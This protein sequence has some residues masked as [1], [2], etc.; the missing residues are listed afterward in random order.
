MIHP[1]TVPSNWIPPRTY[2]RARKTA[3]AAAELAA[4]T[5]RMSIYTDES[6]INNKVG[7]AAWSIV[8]GARC[9]YLGHLDEYTVYF[10][11]VMA[12]DLDLT[13]ILEH[14]RS[15]KKVPATVHIFI[16]NQA[17]ILT[18]RNPKPSSG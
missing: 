4:N 13:Q 18:I 5:S 10:A 15:I 12:V 1:Y 14:N 11:E 7:A 17:A 2:I 16:D 9:L 6:G 3:R 8:F